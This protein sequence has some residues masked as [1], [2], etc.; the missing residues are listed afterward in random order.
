MGIYTIVFNIVQGNFVAPIVYG[1]AV[2]I[3][4]AIVLLAIPAG[5][6]LAGIAGMFLVVPVI[7][8]IATT[9]RMGLRVFAD[10][11][12]ADADPG[13]RIGATPGAGQPARRVDR[14]AALTPG[15]EARPGNGDPAPTGSTRDRDAESERPAGRPGSGGHQL[16][17]EVLELGVGDRAGVLERPGAWPARRPS[18][19]S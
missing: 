1:R 15:P 19:R 16:R 3:H 17:L 5:M 18:R 4:P 7:G 8:V 10:G 9:W 14:R 6:A 11:P 13:G 12:V 2:N